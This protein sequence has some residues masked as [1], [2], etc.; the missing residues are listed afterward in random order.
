[1]DKIEEKY[2]ISEL[3]DQYGKLLTE[4]QRDFIDLYYNED[5]SFGE[6][7]ENEEISRQA[8]HDAIQHGKKALERFE[9]HLGL[10]NKHKINESSKNTDYID[11]NALKDGLEEIC[12]I[13]KNDDILYDT[14]SLRKK[15]K[16]LLELIGGK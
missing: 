16:G 7:A 8:V 12:Y 6:I 9:D 5:L 11:L 15:V 2:H 3:L 14:Q 13:L 1:M 4:R 10:V